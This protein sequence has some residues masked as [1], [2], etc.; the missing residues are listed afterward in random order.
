LSEKNLK[1]LIDN[2]GISSF[3]TLGGFSFGDHVKSGEMF[4]KGFETYGKKDDK[5]K[6][7]EM[8]LYTG[9][10]RSKY[11]KNKVTLQKI[12]DMLQVPKELVDAPVDNWIEDHNKDWYRIAMQNPGEKKANGEPKKFLLFVRKDI[13]TV[14]GGKKGDYEYVYVYIKENTL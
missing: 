12:V 10:N 1:S 4:M 8:G 14:S 11:S 7:Y 3:V 6:E 9:F 5:V 2:G 13:M